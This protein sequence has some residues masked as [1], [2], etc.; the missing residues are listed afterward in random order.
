LNHLSL[1]SIRLGSKEIQQWTG[2]R[3][4]AIDHIALGLKFDGV[5]IPQPT[6]VVHS[7]QPYDAAALLANLKAARI[8]ESGQKD[9][10]RVRWGSLEPVL[11][12]PPQGQTLVYAMTPKQLDTAVNGAERGI[13]HFAAPLREVLQE[14]LRQ[15]LPVW[16]AGHSDHWEQTVLKAWL[17]A[18][19][20]ADQ[21]L[22]MKIRTFG[23][24]IQLDGQPTL[25]TAASCVDAAAAKELAAYLERW[26]QP[27]LVNPKVIADGTWVSGQARGTAK[28]VRQALRPT[29]APDTDD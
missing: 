5:L 18:L 21:D 9:R 29:S 10:Y 6:L 1:G 12:C 16:L 24:W 19:P 25:S 23:V 22:L 3:W 27:P 11:W 7:R 15:P 13:D 17:L 20:Q 4:D 14:R 28:A 2:L 8:P 26:A